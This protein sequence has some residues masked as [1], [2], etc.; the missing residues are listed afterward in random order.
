M[1]VA[2]AQERTIGQFINLVRGTGWQLGSINRNHESA[3]ALL[4]FNPITVQR[5]CTCPHPHN[6]Q[7]AQVQ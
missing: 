3:V 5:Q 6:D 4:I 7:A 2:N 1:A